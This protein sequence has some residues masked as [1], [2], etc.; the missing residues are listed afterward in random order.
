MP[1]PQSLRNLSTL[2]APVPETLAGYLLDAQYRH[3]PEQ[4][5]RPSEEVLQQLSSQA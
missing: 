4:T 1:T 5:P 2:L 3:R